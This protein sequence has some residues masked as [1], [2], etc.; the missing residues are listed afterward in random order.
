MLLETADVTSIDLDE[1]SRNF[2]IRFRFNGRSYK[3][4]LKTSDRRS[5]DARRGQV[6]GTLLLIE[7]GRLEI[8]PGVDPAAFILSD[9]KRTGAEKK[10][11][12]L[13]IKQLFDRYQAE[14]PPGAKEETTLA[15][16]KIHFQHLLRHLK[17]SSLAE[18]LT[19][20][21]AQAYVAKRMK[22]TWR[23]KNIGGETVKKELTTLRLVW[24]WAA[25]MGYLQGK[26]PVVDIQIPTADEKQ[27]FRTAVEI[28]QI[29]KRGGVKTDRQAEL[30]AGL[31]LTREEV[32]GLLSHVQDKARHDFIYPMYVFAAHT[33][34]RRSEILRAEVDDFD[35]RSKTV[36]IREKKK[37]RKYR[38]TFR[39]VD[40]TGLLTQTMKN[41]FADHPGGQFAITSDGLNP[42]TRDEAHVHFKRALTG[43]SWHGKLRGFHVLRHS[44]CSNLAAAGVD[45]RI[46]DKFVG[47][48][49]EAMRKRYQHLAPDVTKRAIELLNV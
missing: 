17:G 39:R 16:E 32:S 24:N 45:Q 15:G 49:T 6:D 25:K 31:Y 18:S 38:T 21:D 29:I 22:D 9:G 41:W 33:G 37:S 30:W 10:R 23:G 46:I 8:P 27:I 43:S 35:F 1:E 48:T 44:F 12:R 5:A 11:E 19:V 14:L 34:A 40:M 36:Q 42:L 2:R 20:P 47:H 7:S 3:R 13:T 4:T 26:S 28:E